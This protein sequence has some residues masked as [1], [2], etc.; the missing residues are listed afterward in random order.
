MLAGQRAI[1][2]LHQSVSRSSNATSIKRIL[3]NLHCFSLFACVESQTLL[4]NE[5]T[6]VHV[7]KKSP[8]NCNKINKESFYF[9][10]FLTQDSVSFHAL[11]SALSLC[12]SQS[13]ASGKIVQ[14]TKLCYVGIQHALN[15]DE[16]TFTLCI[17][18]HFMYRIYYQQIDS[19]FIQSFIVNCSR[20]F[21]F[22]TLATSVTQ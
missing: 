6:S 14:T 15:P 18:Q 9:F 20:C 16:N 22:N 5:S 12:D 10:S 7:R 1:R 3:C 17:G 4:Q 2:L 21:D 19:K 8:S 13:Y 11:I